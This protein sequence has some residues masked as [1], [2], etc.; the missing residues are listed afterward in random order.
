MWILKSIDFFFLIKS[1]TQV[2]VE[3]S[4]HHDLINPQVFSWFLSFLRAL[5]T[6]SM[7]AKI[8]TFYNFIWIFDIEGKCFEW[9]CVPTSFEIIH[10]H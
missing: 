5:V 3:D 1:S 6:S 10:H 8:D 4:F 2:E 9:Y 7:I